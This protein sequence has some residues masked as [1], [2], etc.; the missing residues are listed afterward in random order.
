[1]NGQDG[2]NLADRFPI[3]P[4]WSKYSNSLKIKK[5]R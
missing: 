1:M 2:Q 3:I 4:E 5:L